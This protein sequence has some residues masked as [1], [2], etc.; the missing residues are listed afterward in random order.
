V[1]GTTGETPLLRFERD[2]AA[3]LKALGG[4]PP[5]RQIRELVRRV[6]ADQVWA[7]C[8]VAVDGNSYSVP[9]RLIGESVRVVVADGRVHIHHA[10]V[11][12]AVH[13]ETTGRRQRI[14]DPAHF[15]GVAG[16]ARPASTAEPTATTA[17][18]LLRPLAEYERAVGGSWA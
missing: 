13:P 10:G 9:W 11:E 18:E 12:V 6:Q 1:H 4:R 16:L 17:A 3:A 5:F 14:T 8:A 2:E 15:H 7:A